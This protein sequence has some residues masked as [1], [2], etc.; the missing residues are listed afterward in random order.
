LSNLANRH[1]N[2][3]Q[4]QQC[5][6]PQ[7]YCMVP[8]TAPYCCDACRTAA[9]DEPCRCGHDHCVQEAR[10]KTMESAEEA[11]LRHSA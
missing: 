3:A 4:A 8:G 1:M 7:C 10:V 6:H 2:P 11:A 5:S 9:P